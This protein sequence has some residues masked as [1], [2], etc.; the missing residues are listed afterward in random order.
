MC[1]G[2]GGGTKGWRVGVME[3]QVGQKG[4]CRTGNEG[5]TEWQRGWEGGGGAKRGRVGLTGVGVLEGEVGQRGKVG[6]ENEGGTGRKKRESG[7]Y[8]GVLEGELGQ[9]GKDGTRGMR[10]GQ[11]EGGYTKGGKVGL[12]EGWDRE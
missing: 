3:G 6:T 12:V 7:T 1:V 10:M 4:K 8:R 9:R 2:G 11:E 5:R